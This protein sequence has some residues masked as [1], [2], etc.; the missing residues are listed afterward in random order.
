MDFRVVVA[1]V[2]LF[3]LETLTIYLEAFLGPVIYSIYLKTTHFSEV[4]DEVVVEGTLIRS[5]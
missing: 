3:T 2:I 5:E 4:A 1:V